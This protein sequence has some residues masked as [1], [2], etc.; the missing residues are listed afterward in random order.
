MS[1]SSTDFRHIALATLLALGVATTA[2]SAGFVKNSDV[3]GYRVI[4]EGG[5]VEKRK[6]IQYDAQGNEVYN[7]EGFNVKLLNGGGIDSGLLGEDDD[8]LTLNLDPAANLDKEKSE[9][10][11]TTERTKAP[12]KKS[13]DA[14]DKPP[15]ERETRS[16]S[17]TR[18]AD[19]DSG[20]IIV[21]PKSSLLNQPTTEDGRKL[22]FYLAGEKGYGSD[23]PAVT[24]TNFTKINTTF[25]ENTHSVD[26]RGIETTDRYSNIIS[27]EQWHAKFSPLGGRRT[28]IY[29]VES[30]FSGR[31]FLIDKTFE[32]KILENNLMWTHSR[33]SHISTDSRFAHQLA[34][35]YAHPRTSNFNDARLPSP[36]ERGGI[37]MQS[38]NRYHF[39]RSHSDKEGL[40][41]VSPGDETIRNISTH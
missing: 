40:E 25:M 5:G 2:T 20:A 39:R 27:L 30:N 22:P 11:E 23:D 17:V 16:H 1:F 24:L 38:I 19:D 28:D 14:T 9:V 37:S 3:G 31:E 35:K 21:D 7:S 34:E 10:K 41:T 6:E 15:R 33:E 26:S 36:G 12:I 8:E 32:R 13:E 4:V 29:D 18:D